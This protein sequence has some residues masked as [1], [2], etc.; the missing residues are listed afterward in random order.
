M[1]SPLV[2]VRSEVEQ[3]VQS[4]REGDRD[5]FGELYQRF[6]G[7]LLA[8]CRRRT[9]ND[10]EAQELCQDVFLQAMRKLTSLRETAAFGGWLRTI[11]TR[12]S[13]NRIA[14]RRPM[15]TA[16][17]EMLDVVG[18]DH[19]S[20]LEN[21]MATESRQQVRA[22]L[23]QL[24][25]LDR[26]TLVAFYVHGQSLMEMSEAFDAPLGTIKRRLFDARKRLAAA[27]EVASALGAGI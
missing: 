24:K 23:D 8:F 25:D 9:N 20:P 19:V 2:S 13:I 3:L 26:Q 11:A 12:L 6:H 16:N 5:A 15:A 14:R 27:V 7:Q 10:A 18:R 22:G 21:I 4:A 1:T 17:N